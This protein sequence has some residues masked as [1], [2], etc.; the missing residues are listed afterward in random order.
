MKNVVCLHPVQV[1]NPYTGKLMYV[2]CGKC[3]LCLN[4]RA[5]VWSNRIQKECEFHK[6]GFTFELDYKNEHL[7]KLRIHDDCLECISEN[8][9]ISFDEFKSYSFESKDYRFLANRSW[10]PFNSRKNIQKF[11]KRLRVNLVRYFSLSAKE[12]KFRYFCCGEYGPTTYRPHVHFIIWCDNDKLASVLYSCILKSWKVGRC[13]E[14]KPVHKNSARYLANYVTC[15][16]HLPKIYSIPKIS[17]FQLCSRRPPLGTYPLYSEEVQKMFYSDSFEISVPKQDTFENIIIPDIYSDRLFPKLP[18]FDELHI[19]ERNKIYEYPVKFKEFGP[20]FESCKQV[21]LTY[22]KNKTF[23]EE[24]ISS[25]FKIGYK[26]YRDENIVYTKLQDKY[27]DIPLD[28]WPWHILRTW[29]S[30]AHLVNSLAHIFDCSL[31]Y[32]VSRIAD[33]YKT[34]D[35]WNLH[36][37]LHEK[38]EYSNSV[39]DIKDCM[40]FDYGRL[41]EI[42]LKP[43]EHYS[44][45]DWFFL[46]SFGFDLEL[47]DPVQLQ[48]YLFENNKLVTS[49]SNLEEYKRSW[50]TK[51][52]YNRDYL[53]KISDNPDYQWAVAYHLE[54]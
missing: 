47:F 7:P 5:Q 36:Q 37:A 43:I 44:S 24:Y 39:A 1:I 52:K 6:Y 4:R 27:P 8:I 48:P 51:T 41:K 2:P 45:S 17:Q 32:Y 29:Y 26:K 10:I 21:A 20:F 28:D 50:N 35:K 11:L 19:G 31:I 38:V 22:K 14:F 53:D 46:D 12:A 49:V 23:I 33:F 25:L 3:D 18:F 34:K 13:R 40:V 30:A 15:T 42:S 9:C 54:I 16:A